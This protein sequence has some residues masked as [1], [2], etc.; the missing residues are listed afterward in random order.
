MPKPRDQS[1]FGLLEEQH[2]GWWAGVEWEAE[3]G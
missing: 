3:G 2:G 1:A